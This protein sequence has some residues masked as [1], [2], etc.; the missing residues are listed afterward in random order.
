VFSVL[1]LRKQL[2]WVQWFALGL[3]IVGVST[4]QMHGNVEQNQNK[5][6]L[7]TA[8]EKKNF[9]VILS[10]EPRRER[11]EN[12]ALGILA[13]LAACLMSGFAGVYYE[14]LLKNTPPSICLR[15][16]QLGALGVVFG[17]MAAWFI[18]GTKV[19]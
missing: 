17:S 5:S 10:T 16:V 13:V 6:T 4:V 9:S 18:D 11:K 14:K 8:N 1:I 2:S 3:L 19:S 12:F 15:N 7:F